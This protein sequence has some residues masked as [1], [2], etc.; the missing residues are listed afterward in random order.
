MD[1]A[2]LSGHIT[3]E[4]PQKLASDWVRSDGLIYWFGLRESPSDIML[5]EFLS[6]YSLYC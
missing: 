4:C 3:S 6:G 5:V 1:T 2:T